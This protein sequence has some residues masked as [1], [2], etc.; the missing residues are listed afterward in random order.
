MGREWKSQLVPTRSRR[1]QLAA[2]LGKRP[3]QGPPRVLRW[4]LREGTGL[5]RILE[6]DLAGVDPRGQGG[7]RRDRGGL[8]VG[9]GPAR[10]V[11]VAGHN[12]AP[13]RVD[14]PGKFRD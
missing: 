8:P 11:A 5:D 9:E 14:E 2:E 7:Q 6:R 1:C 13:L 3:Y 10:M 12:D 4:M